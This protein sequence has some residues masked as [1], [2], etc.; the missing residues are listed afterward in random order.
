MAHDIYLDQQ[1]Y[2][3]LVDHNPREADVFERLRGETA[4]IPKLSHMQISPVQANF[5]Q[6]LVRLSGAKM[7]LEVG[8][9]TGL[10]TMALALCLPDDGKVT[11]LDY[12][13]DW[14]GMAGKY[15]RETKVDHKIEVIIG[16]AMETLPEFL[17]ETGENTIDMAFID[18]DKRNMATYF[19]LC[20]KLVRPGGL[21]IV[22]NVLWNGKVTDI[23]ANQKDTLAIRAFNEAI[24]HD[25]RVHYTMVP[26]GDGMTLAIKK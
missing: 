10:S 13:P 23:E 19:E 26:V 20:L 24:L 4:T 9:F 22:D 21:I 17:K 8:T 6:Q 15:W 7:C 18:A 11:T 3:Y 14:V 5:M 2:N 16:D 1:L 12:W 25:E